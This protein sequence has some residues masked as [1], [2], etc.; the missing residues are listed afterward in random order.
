MKQEQLHQII[1]EKNERRE[2][3]VLRTAEQLI[4]EII[5]EQQQINISTERIRTLRH[6]LTA[7]QVQELSAVTILG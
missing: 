2:R 4:E 3:D 6:D 7:L 1:Q 5:K